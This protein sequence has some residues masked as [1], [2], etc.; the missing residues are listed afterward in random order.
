MNFKRYAV[1]AALSAFALAGLAPA[2][3]AQNYRGTFTLPFEAQWGNAHL[4]PGE[5]TVRTDT[6][7]ATPVMYLTGNGVAQSILSGPVRTGEISDKGSHL[8]LT[9]INGTYVVSKLVAGGVGKEFS[10]ATPRSLSREQGMGI[11]LKKATLPV[12]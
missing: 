3:V 7:V 11:A 5:Y 9:E 10:F 12:K 2:A 4:Q 8:E 1:F 6:I